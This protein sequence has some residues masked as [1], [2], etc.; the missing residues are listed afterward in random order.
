MSSGQDGN[1]CFKDTCIPSFLWKRLYICVWVCVGVCACVVKA[2]VWKF[3]VAIG[4][5]NPR[6]I[7]P[8]SLV[9]VGFN[10]LVNK[11]FSNNKPQFPLMR[12][13]CPV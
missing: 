12:S 6:H 3:R 8:D 9:C 10:I 5:D 1:K 2:G 4:Q 11:C 13:K 7:A